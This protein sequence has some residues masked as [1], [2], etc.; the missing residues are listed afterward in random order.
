MPHS[1]TITDLMKEA[2]AA[3]IIEGTPP[4][5]GL[6][7]CRCGHEFAGVH[8]HAPVNCNQLTKYCHLFE[9]ASCTRE[10]HKNA[11]LILLNFVKS[12]LPTEIPL[13]HCPTILLYRT[14]ICR[15]SI[16]VV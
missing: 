7:A 6:N 2:H 12:L 13:L 11:L 3:I 9:I 1:D 15:Y 14:R 10:Y 5:A 4:Y 16:T 8:A